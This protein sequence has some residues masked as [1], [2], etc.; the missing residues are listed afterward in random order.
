MPIKWIEKNGEHRAKVDEFTLVITG[1]G[2]R[3]ECSVKRGRQV[4]PGLFKATSLEQLKAD[5]EEEY[6]FEPRI[7][8]DR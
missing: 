3:W 4:S 2:D 6:G 8:Y 5:L 7:V 1:S